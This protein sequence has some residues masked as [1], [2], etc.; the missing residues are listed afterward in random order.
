MLVYVDDNANEHPFFKRICKSLNETVVCVE[1][2]EDIPRGDEAVFLDLALT[3]TTGID[4]VKSFCEQFPG[5]KF[6]VIS[7]S[8]DESIRTE[9]I[10][11][12]A[13]DY[14]DKNQFYS[15]QESR[16]IINK[17]LKRLNE[18]I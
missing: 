13:L 7:G 2:I 9:S 16:E 10:E 17:A 11:L 5:R 3:R 12:G 6:F 18:C 14:L 15:L 8:D 1:S 4:T